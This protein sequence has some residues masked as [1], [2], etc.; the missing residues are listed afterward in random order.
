MRR[1]WQ[2][3]FPTI[4]VGGDLADQG[5]NADDEQELLDRVCAAYGGAA[6][7][8]DGDALPAL[9]GQVRGGGVFSLF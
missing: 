7:D 4:F 5:Y 2:V 3:A 6:A 9:C 8:D 1:R